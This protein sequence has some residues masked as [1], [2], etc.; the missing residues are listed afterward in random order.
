MPVNATTTIR[1]MSASK[2]MTG[3][4]GMSAAR[5]KALTFDR[6]LCDD[7]E[8]SG[9][10]ALDADEARERLVTALHNKIGISSV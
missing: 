6:L 1:A 9:V 7:L 2:T 4:S 3:L 5:S 8:G 10:D